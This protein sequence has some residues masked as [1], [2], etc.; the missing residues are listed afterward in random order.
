MRN[1]NRAKTTP[2]VSVRQI[3][4]MQN[5]QQKNSKETLLSQILS[6]SLKFVFIGKY[7]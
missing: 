3:V 2:N 4:F 5:I 6:K 7:G 1:I